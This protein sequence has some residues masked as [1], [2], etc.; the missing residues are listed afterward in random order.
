MLN[1]V[2]VAKFL[3]AMTLA[4]F[5]TGAAAG[6]NGDDPADDGETIELEIPFD[7][8][9]ESTTSDDTTDDESDDAD[10]SEADDADEEAAEEDA[11]A[12]V[13]EPKESTHG[14]IVSNC[15]RNTEATGRDHGAAVST[16][17]KDDTAECA[18][19]PA[20]S[21][22]DDEAPAPAAAEDD[23]EADADDEAKEEKPRATKAQGADHRNDKAT[24]KLAE[25]DARKAGR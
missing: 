3:T 8:E 12:V 9:D 10:D 13:D 5:A 1:K 11:D 19:L 18:G 17:A 7:D 24:E 6:I 22:G 4:G 15:A 23:D 20:E 16:V 2:L 14:S 21:A 25:R